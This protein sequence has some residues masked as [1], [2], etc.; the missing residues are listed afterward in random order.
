MRKMFRAL[1]MSPAFSLTISP[2]VR[3]HASLCRSSATRKR[4]FTPVTIRL[5]LQ[6]EAP[7]S[8]K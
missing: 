6:M 5:R 8:I 3:P 7:L 1:S 4:N 2:A